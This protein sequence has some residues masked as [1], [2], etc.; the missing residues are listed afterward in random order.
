VLESVSSNLISNEQLLTARD[1]LDSY[2]LFPTGYCELAANSLEKQFNLKVVTGLFVLA[3]G[4]GTPHTW[5]LDV[6]TNEIIDLTADQFD[7]SLGPLL[8]TNLNSPL[9]KKHYIDVPVTY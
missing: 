3:N 4:Q 5:N 6:T 8:R 7:P 9:A 1:K 2:Q